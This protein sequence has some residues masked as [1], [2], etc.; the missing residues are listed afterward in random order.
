MPCSLAD[1]LDDVASPRPRLSFEGELRDAAV[2]VLLMRASQGPE[3]DPNI[4]LIER[5]S[6]LRNHGGQVAFPGGKPD[7]GDDSL[8][9]TALRE[10][11][12]EV[13][14]VREG[15]EV[16]GRLGPV[17][18]PT[19]FAIWPYVAWA[20]VGWQ[21]RNTSEDEVA[22]VLTPKLSTLL[23]PSVHAI[24]GRGV[25]KG[26]AYEMHEFLIHEPPVWGATARILWDL[27]E[28]IR[29]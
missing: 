15:V 2:V 17:P 24:T 29:R 18:T 23:D 25:W 9:D 16:L 5:A 28:R 6:A 11:S 22:A 12:E 3:A 13:G 19:G 7:E 10:A 1:R 14:L 27:L 20:P 21:P 8:L 4:V 26:F